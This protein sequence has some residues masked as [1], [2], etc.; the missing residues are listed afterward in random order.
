V[1]DTPP[2]DHLFVSIG[3][4]GFIAGVATAFKALSPQTVIHGVETE[5]ADCMSQ[6]LAAGAPVTIRPTSIAR[7]LGAPFATAR[8]LAAA[9]AMLSEVIRV[10]DREAVRDLL[11]ILEAERI[12]VEPAAACVLTAAKMRAASFKPGARIGLVLCGSTVPLADV[13]GWTAQ[14]GL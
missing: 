9:Q 3:G 4:G 2:L 14:F 8:T 5:G 1:Q 10:P 13:T 11:A 12:L 7:T 6:A